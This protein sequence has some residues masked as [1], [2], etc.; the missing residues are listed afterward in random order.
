MAYITDAKLLLAGSLVKIE[1]PRSSSG[2]P[3]HPH[4]F[5]VLS[6]P[7]PISVGSF[8]HADMVVSGHVAARKPVLCFFIICI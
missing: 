7:D 5:I 6:M 1:R 8:V 3:T 4:F 2:K